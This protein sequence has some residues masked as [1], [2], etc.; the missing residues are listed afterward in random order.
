MLTNHDKSAFLISGAQRDFFDGGSMRI[1]AAQM[2]ISDCVE[3]ARYFKN[4]VVLKDEHPPGHFS[5]A[6]SHDTHPQPGHILTGRGTF[7]LLPDHCISGTPGADLLLPHDLLER[8]HILRR[9]TRMQQSG[10]AFDR[11]SG[12]AAWLKAGGITHLAIGGLGLEHEL[13]DTAKQARENGF[14]VTV[15]EDLCH[16]LLHDYGE[17]VE[18]ALRGLQTDLARHG[19]EFAMSGRYVPA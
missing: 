6:S 14:H 18:A 17:D 4:V 11:S 5:F 1:S 19:V 3:F 8:A 15:M 12:L 16:G 9:G 13:I 10:A 7:P 2:I